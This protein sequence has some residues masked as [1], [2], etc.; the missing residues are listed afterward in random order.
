MDL[1][2]VIDRR[3]DAAQY[4]ITKSLI[5]VPKS[6]KELPALRVKRRPANIWQTFLRT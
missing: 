4:M 1:K 5:S 2:K 3:D 6:K